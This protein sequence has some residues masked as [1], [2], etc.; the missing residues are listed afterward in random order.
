MPFIV[1]ASRIDVTG[2]LIGELAPAGEPPPKRL[3]E[4]LVAF[5][6]LCLSRRERGVG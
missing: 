6:A 4:R 2:N 5:A 3:D 1:F